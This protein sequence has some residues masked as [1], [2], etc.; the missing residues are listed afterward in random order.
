MELSRYI[1]ILNIA[2]RIIKRSNHDVQIGDAISSSARDVFVTEEHAQ[3][4]QDWLYDMLSPY[5]DIYRYVWHVSGIKLKPGQVRKYRLKWL[6]RLITQL[7]EW[8]KDEVRYD[9]EDW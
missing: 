5:N 6:K 3:K 4:V 8:R 7:E 2:R 1:Y 9:E